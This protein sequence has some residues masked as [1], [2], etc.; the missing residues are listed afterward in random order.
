MTDGCV[1]DKQATTDLIVEL[2]FHPVS[3]IIVGIG[4][5]N[6]DF[7]AILDADEAVLFDSNGRQAARDLV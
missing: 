2:S 1:H 4:D 7:L 5:A 6:F 3:I